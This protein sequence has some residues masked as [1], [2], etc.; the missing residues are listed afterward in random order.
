MSARRAATGDDTGTGA[1]RSTCRRLSG[2]RV[3]GD[4]PG[5]LHVSIPADEDIAR[6]LIRT[7]RVPLCRTG[8]DPVPARRRGRQS[9]DLAAAAAVPTIDE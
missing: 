2:R 7:P 1:L 8:P 9:A 4:R 5:L 6:A 3:P